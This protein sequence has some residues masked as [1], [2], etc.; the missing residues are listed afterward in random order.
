[1]ALRIQYRKKIHGV[2]MQSGHVYSMKY[3]P[4]QHDSNPTIIFMNSFSG[5]HPNTGRQ[6]RFIQALNFTYVPR[7]SRRAFA[8]EWTRV[9]ERTNG[10]V[11]FTWNILKRRYPY[12]SH[13]V[14]R[15][16]YSPNYYISKLQEI[17]FENMEQ[18][19]ISTWSK[20]FSKKVKV[21]LLQKFRSAMSGRKD[22]KRKAKRSM[23]I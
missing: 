15:Y 6:W 12:L 21:S 22:I 9:F 1:M 11:R 2:I 13:A 17:P 19:I 18:A 7:S 23:Q 8:N 4:W 10:N 14:R 16:F 3:I 20:D 5:T